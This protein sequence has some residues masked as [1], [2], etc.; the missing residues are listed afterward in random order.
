LGVMC[1]MGVQRQYLKTIS[2]IMEVNSVGGNGI[3]P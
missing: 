1:A 2:Y 3:T